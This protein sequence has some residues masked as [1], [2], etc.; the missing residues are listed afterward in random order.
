MPRYQFTVD[1]IAEAET[2]EKLDLVLDQMGM[3][4]GVEDLDYKSDPEE[5]VEDP[6][7]GDDED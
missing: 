4:P 5:I 3:V 1:V 7:E 2:R 6:E